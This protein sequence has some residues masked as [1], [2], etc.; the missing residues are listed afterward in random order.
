MNP[1][2]SRSDIQIRLIQHTDN[3]TV[4]EM[5]RLV[6]RNSRPWDVVNSRLHKQKAP[7]KPG[8]F[9]IRIIWK[10]AYFTPCINLLM[11]GATTR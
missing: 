4:A 9:E 6:R 7:A 8:L 5:I 2:K 3:S 11:S 10:M 1:S